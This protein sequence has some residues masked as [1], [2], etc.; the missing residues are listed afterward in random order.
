MHQ[1]QRIV[2]AVR[3]QIRNGELAPGDRV[4]STRELTRQWGVAMATATK[5]LTA[6][7][8]EG[9]VRP[10][11]GIGTVVAGPPP[12]PGSRQTGTRH[13]GSDGGL[14][15]ERIVAAAV[16]LADADGLRS[17]S[18]RRVAAELG[19]STMALYRHV[20]DK[21]D[22]VL[23]MLD[24]VLREWH[25]PPKRIRDWRKQLET[26]ARTLWQ[27]FRAHPW[28]ATALSI[29]RPE[30]IAGGMAYTE[31]VLAVLER[32]GLEQEDMLV[33]HLTL[34]NYVRGTAVNLVIEAAAEASTG[35]TND[36]WMKAQEPVV[37]SVLRSGDFP[38]LSRINE[39][40]LGIDVE[41]LFETGL[42]YLIDGLSGSTAGVRA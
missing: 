38:V 34:F 27:G 39:A 36:E 14:V 8:H 37:A 2:A 21:D 22:L 7:R 23:Q 19:V 26:A 11:A 1:Y 12:R 41:A 15:L 18:M 10:V 20:A 31:Y 17:L 25:P 32:R 40:D 3:E 28:L 4:P 16:A 35:M 29:T 42:R 13:T 24:T 9:L 6:L 30:P 33:A 5:A